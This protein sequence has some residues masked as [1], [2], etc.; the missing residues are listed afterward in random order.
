MHQIQEGWMSRSNAKTLYILRNIAQYVCKTNSRGP[1]LS[2]VTAG[3][4][5]SGQSAEWMCC[6]ANRIV[7]VETR[8]GCVEVEFRPGRSIVSRLPVKHHPTWV[9][10]GVKKVTFPP[11]FSLYYVFCC[12]IHWIHFWEGINENCFACLIILYTTH[13]MHKPKAKL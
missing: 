12:L 10:S 4:L 5:Q 11:C 7:D 6:W 2:S 9:C 8:Q 1:R 3:R 13:Y